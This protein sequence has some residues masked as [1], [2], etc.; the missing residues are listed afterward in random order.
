MA[1]ADSRD[2]STNPSTQPSTDQPPDLLNAT[3]ARVRRRVLVSRLLAIAAS[4]LLLALSV[5]AAYVLAARLFGLPWRP[6]PALVV[7]LCGSVLLTAV[8]AAF[9]LRLSLFATAVL[10]DDRLRLRE[11]VSSA[12]SVLSP[13][14]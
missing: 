4:D 2:P 10:T 13:P 14:C 1:M 7:A 6:V 11:R 12:V 3:L 5:L 8:R 9:G